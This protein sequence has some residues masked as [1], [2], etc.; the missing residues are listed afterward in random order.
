MSYHLSDDMSTENLVRTMQMAIKKRVTAQP[1]IHHLDRGLQYCSA[2]Y[3][4]VLNKH[5]N[6]L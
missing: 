5:K 3:Q 2:I 4:K 1:L 6:R